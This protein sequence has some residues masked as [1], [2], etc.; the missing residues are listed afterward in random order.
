ME[1]TNEYGVDPSKL[2]KEEL[3]NEI[4]FIGDFAT[5]NDCIRYLYEIDAELATNSLLKMMTTNVDDEN[6]GDEFFQAT[7]LSSLFN[8]KAVAIKYVSNNHNMMHPYTLAVAIDELIIEDEDTRTIRE[9]LKLF[10]EQNKK[11]ISV[12]LQNT[13]LY[14]DTVEEFLESFN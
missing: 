14:K 10:V 4:T 3:V 1:I 12:E 2:S 9:E 5:M 13:S 6:Y 7:F 8:D 11:K